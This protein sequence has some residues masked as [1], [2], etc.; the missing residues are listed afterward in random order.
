MTAK[1][2]VGTVAVMRS[3][4]GIAT[5]RWRSSVVQDICL[6]MA[7]LA[8][9]ELEIALDGLGAECVGLA[10][11]ATVPLAVRRRL[12]I[13][14]FLC[15]AV[16]TPTLDRALGSPWG[17]SANALVFVV[18]AA[19]Y[20]LGAHAPL[21]RSIPAVVGAMAWLAGLEAIWGDG[22]DYGF[23]VLL[24]GVPW[25]SGRGVRK[26]RHRAARLRELATRLEA[27]R[28]TSE[29]VAVARERQRMAHEAH[30][31]IAHA[32][33]EMVLQASGAE[34]IVE[35]DA[36]RARKALV[37]VQHTGREAVHELRAV[38]GILRSGDQPALP[39][40]ADEV[41]RDATAPS[42]TRFS[43]AFLDVGVALALLALGI[44]YALAAAAV[45]GHRPLALLLQVLAACA[46]AVR[47]PRPLA[48]LAVATVAYAGEAL[49]VVG[50]PGS[51]TTIGALLLT[52]YSAA[53]HAGRVGAIAAACIAVGGTAGISVLVA[54]AD[55]ADVLLPVTIVGIPW[56]AGRA[57]A[58]YRGQS[59]ALGL[60]A[61]R[62][63]RE[64]DA[65][66]RLAVLD[67]RARVAREL[68]DSVAHAVSVMV[69]QAGAAEHTLD[70]MPDQARASMRAVQDV[71]R[72]A[73]DQLAT[74]LGLL[75]PTDDRPPL[76]PRP[77]L[78]DL[79]GLLAAV[80]QAGLPVR[81]TT[82]G[83]PQPLPAA[84][85]AAAYRIIQEALTNALKHSG[86]APTDVTVR[87]AADGL[88]LDVVDTGGTSGQTATG[89]YGLAGMRERVAHHGGLVRAGPRAGGAGFVVSA[90]LP[91]A[92]VP[93]VESEHVHA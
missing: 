41:E 51:P 30:D 39:V 86:S 47:R 81:L 25:L 82:I 14:S 6:A 63:A 88:H 20:S 45:A 35:R 1:R 67:E 33:G 23:I 53:A 22:E 72:E 54:G 42:R 77:G 50:D 16:L 36:Q 64:R 89:G 28:A 38:L 18:L 8:A 75:Q 32:V 31:V 11:L 70:S 29:R 19:S 10:L 85:D 44:F 62:L 87:F 80:R 49:I 83:E 66:A 40:G 59:E 7:L 34:E 4:H 48:A 55:A 79:E 91:Y 21:R 84:L 90:S 56:L 76:A 37:V 93:R 69:L 17:Q 73:L 27:E 15:V 2:S 60:L 26:Y 71:G 46:V 92:A 74:L 61:E 78:A 57:V 24:L 43:L 58:A 5:G 12:P 9:A 68:H 65:R 3:A 13:A 52:T